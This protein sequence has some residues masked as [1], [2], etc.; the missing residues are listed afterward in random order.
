MALAAITTAEV[1]GDAKVELDDDAV[2][3]V[4]AQQ[5]RIRADNI[6]IYTSAGRT[7]L[8]AK[9]RVE[10]DVFNRYLPAALDDAALD[11]LVADKVAD[12]AAAGLTGMKAMGGVIKAVKEAAGPTADSAAIAARVKAALA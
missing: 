9:S 2:V 11:A 3:A 10:L 5:A 1:A 4:L 12:A 6:E 8:A 7:D